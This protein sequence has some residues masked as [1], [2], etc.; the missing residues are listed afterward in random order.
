[1]STYSSKVLYG[2]LCG[3]GA[4]GVA[5]L[6][7]GQLYCAWCQDMQQIVK[8]IEY[9]WRAKCLDCKFSRWAGLSKHNAGI[10]VNGHISKEP[11]HKLQIEYVRNPTSVRTA[12]RM[13]A[14]NLT[15]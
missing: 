3:H 2:L 4:P 14:W 11:S 9:E 8:V 7:N 1:M 15:S 10:F 12:E 6:V 5:T 13:A